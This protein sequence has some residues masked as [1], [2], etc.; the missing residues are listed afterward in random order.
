MKWARLIKTLKITRKIRFERDDM[1]LLC[2][3]DVLLSVANHKNIQSIEVAKTIWI[4][5]EC[6]EQ[7]GESNLLCILSKL[8]LEVEFLRFHSTQKVKEAFRKLETAGKLTHFEITEKFPEFP[9]SSYLMGIF[10]S[11]SRLYHI[12]SDLNFSSEDVIKLVQAKQDKIQVLNLKKMDYNIVTREKT[13][14]YSEEVF[15]ELSNC[16]ELT[17]LAIKLSIGYYL[18]HLTSMP[19]LMR[20]NLKL[21]HILLNANGELTPN[22]Y[23][24]VASLKIKNA[25]QMGRNSNLAVNSAFLASIGGA[26]PNLKKLS[27]CTNGFSVLEPNTIINLILKLHKLE[28]LILGPLQHSQYGDLLHGVIKSCPNL[29]YIFFKKLP[30][31]QD[32]SVTSDTQALE[33]RKD[34]FETLSEMVQETLLLASN[35]EAIRT[36]DQ[37][38]FM[39]SSAW[40]LKVEKF[41]QLRRD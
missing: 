34:F 24:Q 20:L 14:G 13:L 4:S 39:K 32:T 8:K 36:A 22:L 28:T 6:L 7:L 3:D 2:C 16:K 26:F 35:I 38:V 30:F 29:K 9:M 25:Y 11:C 10:T 27:L 41:C 40:P 18:N 15:K 17:T 31:G 23:T 5:Q 1:L 12:K 21:D 33:T 19:K 37:G